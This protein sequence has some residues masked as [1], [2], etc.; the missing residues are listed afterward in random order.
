MLGRV[1]RRRRKTDEDHRAVS[2]LREGERPL[3]AHCCT[4]RGLNIDLDSI[5]ENA[6]EEMHEDARDDLSGIDELQ[7]AVDAFNK[8]NESVRTWDPDYK[9][10]V[11]IP[12][13][14]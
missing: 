5:L 6:T 8:A 13:P 1:G 7:S 3:F 9:R 11:S 4:S 10:K 14:V 12:V 2:L